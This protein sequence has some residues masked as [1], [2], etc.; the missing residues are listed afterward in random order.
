VGAYRCS[1]HNI[2]YPGYPAGGKCMVDGCGEHTGWM[3]SADPTPGWEKHVDRYNDRGEAVF[4]T[5]IPIPDVDADVTSYGG[6]D[7]V[8]HNDLIRAGYRNLE[9]FQ[10]VL[11]RGS[12]YEL[13]GH[14][15][16]TLTHGISGGA[17]WVQPVDPAQEAK[18]L[19]ARKDF[20]LQV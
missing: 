16:R 14:V 6:M 12:Y 8:A 18:D 9:D 2:N 11:V 4:A 1:L 7:W 3:M 20:L 13:Q 17:W 19:F 15:G 5:P 10:V